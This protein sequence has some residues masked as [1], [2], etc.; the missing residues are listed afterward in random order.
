M[1]VPMSDNLPDTYAER[2]LSY[3][4][5]LWARVPEDYKPGRQL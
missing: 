5:A 1:T 4:E 3:V 2:K